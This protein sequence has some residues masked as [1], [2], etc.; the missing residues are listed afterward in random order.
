MREQGVDLCHDPGVDPTRFVGGKAQR[1]AEIPSLTHKAEQDARSCRL[2]FGGE[3]VLRFIDNDPGLGGGIF[4][5]SVE[6]VPLGRVVT[7]TKLN[8][9]RR[10]GGCGPC[11]KQLADEQEDDDQANVV[12]YT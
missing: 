6:P 12:G 7:E 5:Y 11:E 2:S 10:L 1:K 9:L 4:Q 8:R 3:N